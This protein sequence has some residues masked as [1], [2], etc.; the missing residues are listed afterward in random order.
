MDK[1]SLL[2]SRAE[3]EDKFN[4]LG[5]QIKAYQDE[6]LRLQGEYRHVETLL[7]VLKALEEPQEATTI[8]VEPTLKEEDKKHG[9]PKS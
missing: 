4:K 3:L 8:D 1:E 9:K 2:K 5:E 6:Q 7:K